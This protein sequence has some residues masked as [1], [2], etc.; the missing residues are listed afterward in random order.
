MSND[1]SNKCETCA[2]EGEIAL[3]PCPFCN[4][5]VTIRWNTMTG[6]HYISHVDWNSTCPMRPFCGNE[7]QW[8]ERLT[9]NHLRA[10]LDA[11]RFVHK[12]KNEQV[13]LLI[14][15]VRQVSQRADE[16]FIERDKA[17]RDAETLR[18]Q[19]A[20]NRALIL[21]QH[22]HLIDACHVY[23][24]AHSWTPEQYPDIGELLRWLM[25]DAWMTH[26]ESRGKGLGDESAR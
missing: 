1:L 11:C 17:R 21:V 3:L 26:S 6:E 12:G 25:S 15:Q 5:P 24:K 20:D 19:L 9:E 4:Q 13:D 7:A 22:K 10:E 18:E 16:A 2:N 8:N 14:R 23:Q